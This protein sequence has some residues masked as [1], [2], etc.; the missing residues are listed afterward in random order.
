MEK[1]IAEF[2]QKQQDNQNKPQKHRAPC[3][4][5]FQYMKKD[6]N[7]PN[8]TIHSNNSQIT[9]ITID[10]NYLTKKIIAEDLRLDK[11]HKTSHKI[12]IADLIF[13]II[14]VGTTTNDPTQTEVIT[15][16]VIETVPIQTLGIYIIQTT[17]L[18]TPHLTKTET[19]QTKEVDNTQIIDH[20]TIQT[21]DRTTKI[22][23]IDHLTTPEI[24]TITTQIDK[25][26]KPQSPHRN[27]T[28]YTN[29]QQNYRSSTPKNQ[30]QINQVQSTEETQLDPP[31]IDKLKYSQ[32][33]LN[34][35]HCESTESKEN[36]LS[37]NMF[38]IENEYETPIDSNY[39]QNDENFDIFQKS[40]TRQITTNYTK[41]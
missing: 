16:I 37:I 23:L 26:S 34:H 30:R 6:Q 17:I 8:K 24:E 27:N 21:I 31:G 32:L 2:R 3:K 41:Q 29:S 5:F 9:I 39:Y 4:F 10:Y 19:I 22:V 40:D 36:T 7:L 35:I 13:E 38:H 15:Q 33:Q 25:K 11:I 1:C 12:G 14:N 18:E 28:P 20:K